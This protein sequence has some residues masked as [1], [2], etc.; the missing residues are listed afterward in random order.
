M[1]KKRKNRRRRNRNPVLQ[2]KYD[3]GYQD[4][5]E[6]GARS[7][8]Q[9]TVKHIRDI[10]IDLQD[11]PGIGVKTYEKVTDHIE[12]HAGFYGKEMREGQK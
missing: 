8:V 1:T 7:G 2:K 9:R 5:V 4:G 12:K 11:V 6:A 3:E 10:L